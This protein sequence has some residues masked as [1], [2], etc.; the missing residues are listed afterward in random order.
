MTD[1]L[2]V[3]AHCGD[4]SSCTF[5]CDGDWKDHAECAE[6]DAEMFFPRRPGDKGPIDYRPAKLV[7]VRCPVVGQC[8][9]YAERNREE[10][11]V[12]GGLTAKEL[13]TLRYTERTT[14]RTCTWCLAYFASSSSTRRHCCEGCKKAEK[15]AKRGL[16]EPSQRPQKG[17]KKG[18]K[19][20]PGGVFFLHPK[21]HT[22]PPSEKNLPN[23]AQSS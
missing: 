21:R 23:R 9:A 20:P 17:P 1:S 11:G 3:C 12:W 8:R 14:I 5:A 18:Q 4:S 15:Q 13:M 22:P 10:Y 6:M 7:C 16:L 2:D 19:E